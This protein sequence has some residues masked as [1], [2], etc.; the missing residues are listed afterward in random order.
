MSTLFASRAL[1]FAGESFLASTLLVGVAWMASLLLRQAATRHLMWLT[2]FGVSLMLPLAALVV[3]PGIAIAHRVAKPAPSVPIAIDIEIPAQAAVPGMIPAPPPPR[4]VLPEL[5]TRNIAVALF[6]VWLAGF[7]WAMARLGAGAFGLSA[8]KR[9]SRPHALASQDLPRLSGGQ[10]ECELRLSDGEDG[11]LTWGIFRPVVLLPRTATQWPRERLQAVLLHEL[12]HVRRR[13]SLSQLVSL[14]ACA[15]Y[16]PNPLIWLGARALRR[17]AEIAADDTVL[18]LGMR[19]SDYAGALLRVA[20]E[21]HGHAVALSGVAMASGSAL[22]ARVK[23]VLKPNQSRRG[24]TAM[25]FWKTASLGLALTALLAVARPGLVEAEAASDP[26][27]AVMVQ[28][29]E[30]ADAVDPVTP[31]AMDDERPADAPGDVGVQPGAPSRDHVVVRIHRRGHR[32]RVVHVN[33]PDQAEIDR[34]VAKAQAQ[35]RKAEIAL[36]RIEPEIQRAIASAKI[37]ETVA[38]ALE[39][40]HVSEKVAQA[41]EKARRQI[42]K[43]TAHMNRRIVRVQQER[44]DARSDAEDEASDAADEDN[45]AHDDQ[46]DDEGDSSGDNQGDGGT[47]Q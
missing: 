42:A 6:A 8:L 28:P 19:P 13:D 43:E 40:A 1:L 17:E 12:A 44:E 35:A 18:M 29:G 22:E 23:S 38:R 4:P 26:A 41:L 34:E 45:D 37:D 46:G 32:D 25:D 11:P 14:V 2:A 36:A 39:S 3:P 33:M 21:A 15:L 16:W 20:S 10:R 9:R 30:P 7:V 24:V 5:S 27:P 47:P 31:D